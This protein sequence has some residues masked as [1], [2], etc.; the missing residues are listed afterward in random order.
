MTREQ[1]LHR[2]A[3]PRVSRSLGLAAVCAVC[4]VVM[5]LAA[6][7][8]YLRVR[9][10]LNESLDESLRVRAD[11]VAALVA[12]GR[13]SDLR[14]DQQRIAE[15]EEGFV[16]LLTPSGRVRADSLP[17]RT[18]GGPLRGRS[19]G[20]TGESTRTMPPKRSP[21]SAPVRMVTKPPK[22]IVW[23]RIPG[24]RKSM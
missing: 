5:A 13:A 3:D 19:G 7:F 1:R 9:A 12:S 15:S 10:D 2:E 16:Q 24:I 18:G 8:V 11:D 6:T 4:L 20:F 23:T 14:L 22:D 21:Y 17:R